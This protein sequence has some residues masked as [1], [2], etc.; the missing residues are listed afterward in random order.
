MAGRLVLGIDEAGRGPLIGDM[1]IAAVALFEDD[2]NLLMM[3][4]VKDSKRLSPHARSRLFKEIVRLSQF[5]FVRRYPPDIIDIQNINDL[6]LE[7]VQAAV[8]TVISLGFNI[9]TVYVDSPSNPEK[10][11]NSLRN[12]VGNYVELVV[13]YKADEKYIPVSAASIVAKVL[14]DSHINYLRGIYGDFGSGYPSDPRTIKWLKDHLYAGAEPLP[15]IVRRSW[16]TLRKF[17]SKT[18]LDFT[19]KPV[20]P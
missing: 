4:G 5:I 16:G 15:P 2:A 6:F 12:E 18:L 9:T 3:R 14:R 17:R 10:L 8:K 19:S 1:F 11:I 13:D 7:A 20:N